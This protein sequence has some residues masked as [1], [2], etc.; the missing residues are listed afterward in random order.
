MWCGDAKKKSKPTGIGLFFIF[1]IRTSSLGSSS[2]YSVSLGERGSQNSKKLF[3]F[4]LIV[5]NKDFNK[6]ISSKNF[7][8]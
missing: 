6:K 5:R 3:I 1:L 7:S 8:K 2:P 4:I